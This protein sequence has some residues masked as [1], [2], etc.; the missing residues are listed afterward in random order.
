[1][2][3]IALAAGLMNYIFYLQPAASTLASQYKAQNF[4]I[5]LGNSKILEFPKF[6]LKNHYLGILEFPSL[7]SWWN[8]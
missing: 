1:M 5:Y 3:A 7:R 4:K 6:N 8:W 2:R